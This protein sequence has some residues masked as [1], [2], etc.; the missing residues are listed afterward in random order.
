MAVVQMQKLS[1]CGLKKDRRAILDKIQTMGIMEI[2]HL[3]EEDEVFQKVDVSK[4]K[5]NFDK[6]AVTADQSLNLLQMYVPKKPSK[7]ASLEG[8]EV[9]SE[10][11]YNHIIH[12]KEDILKVI[13]HI[14]HID[15]E[16]SDYKAEIVKLENNI[17]SIKPWL[18]LDLPLNFADNVHS[19]MISGM[20]PGKLTMEDINRI[21]AK[22]ESL[23]IAVEPHIVSRSNDHTYVAFFALRKDS[24]IIEDTLST[25]GFTRLYYAWNKTPRDTIDEIEEKIVQL[26]TKISQI[27]MEMVALDTNREKIRIFA[28]YYRIR[29]DKYEVLSHLLQ[30]SNTFVISGYVPTM[31][32]D[33]IKQEIE[34]KYDCNIDIDPINKNEDTPVLLSNNKFSAN[35]EGV[36]NAYGLPGKGEID[37][38]TVMS[39][40]YAFFFGMM[41]SDAGYGALVSIVVLI[42]TKKF[43]N[44]GVG[45]KKALKMFFWCGISTVFWGV[46]FGGYFGDLIPVVSYNF[47]GTEVIPPA[48]WFTPLENPMRL[49][50]FS[51]L[52]GLVHLFT[53]LGIKG[54]ICLKQKA[55]FDFVCDVVFWYVML[56][57]LI[58]ML[59]PSSIF[60]SILQAEVTFPA[61]VNTLAIVLAVAGAAG[62]LFVSGQRSKNFGLNLARGAY[63]LYGITRW[64]SEILSYSRLLALGLATGVIASVVNQMGSMGS[65]VLGVIIFIVAF[66]FGHT[67]NMAINLLGAYVHTNRLQFVEFF[68]KFYEGTGRIFE[69][70]NRKTK[71]ID[72]KED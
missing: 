34:Q 43:P 48:L 62:I 60:A 57:G 56:A 63:N 53:G 36:L 32:V 24:E 58:L 18:S 65:G 67:L 14:Q 1:I 12:K 25:R 39:F 3:L 13:K 19:A 15:K 17:E 31:Y 5:G 8:K 7:F 38:T 66:L 23:G 55:Y 44:M 68:G 11:K 33:D 4:E 61:F 22:V 41:L 52:F 26:K 42:V 28:D 70:F 49:L 2:N 72:V 54:Y 35:M 46:M 10:E 20:L 21:M 50:V 29:S 59:I 71:Y 6:M 27:E 9:I 16:R 47:F 64:L 37:P 30:S 51:L 69:P 40:F 45:M